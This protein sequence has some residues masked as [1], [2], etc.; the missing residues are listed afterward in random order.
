MPK[1]RPLTSIE[2][3]RT[4]AN[5]FTRV[6]DNLRQLATKFGIRPMRVFL[7][8]S[9]WTGGERGQ[10]VEEEV[11]R[12][13]LIPTPRVA[14]MDSVVFSVFHAGTIPVGSV[15]V[16][17]ISTRYTYDQLTGHMDPALAADG[18]KR[19]GHLD[20]VLQPNDFYYLLY[21]DGR[22][23][24]QPVQAKFRLLNFPTRNAENVEWQLMLE[25]IHEDR[26]RDGRS[27]YLQGTQ[28]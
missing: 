25:K 21:E 6:A 3:K 23:D 19:L 11:Q 26:G 10:G 4:L 24:P 9:R 27:Q 2:A 13:E 16:T 20:H 7:V 1:P 12:V 22:G 28:G 5:R 14:S 18:T 15:R 8:W 17:E